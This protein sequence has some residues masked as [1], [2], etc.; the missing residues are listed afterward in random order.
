MYVI[1]A[2]GPGSLEVTFSE[3]VTTAEALRAISQAFA[4]ADAGSAASALCDVSAVERGPGSYLELAVALATRVH[5]GM[6]IAFVA[7]R[8]Q[9]PFL[10]RLARFSGIA[11]GLGI[12]ES[13]A[14]AEQWRRAESPRREP[15]GRV[16][17][18]Y[19]ELTRQ[20]TPTG[21]APPAPRRGAA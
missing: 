20:R 14:E 9:R 1:R 6:R 4:L 15:S 5:P 21:Q 8:P 3:R 16:Q 17:R 11:G 10:A 13:R 2:H 7:A 19:R 12:F 18:H